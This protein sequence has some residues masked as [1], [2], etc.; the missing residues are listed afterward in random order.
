MPKGVLKRKPVPS[1]KRATIDADLHKLQ[2]DYAVIVKLDETSQKR[3]QALES[4][5]K[6]LA[7]FGFYTT[8][9]PGADKTA[10]VIV[11]IKPSK[12]VEVAAEGQV[13]DWAVGVSTQPVDFTN[14]G[15]NAINPALRRRLVYETIIG[16]NILA[17]PCV[18]GAFPAGSP[19]LN[20]KLLLD[21][22]RCVTI[23]YNRLRLQ[24]GENIGL[25]Y[26][27]VRYMLKQLV[28]PATL[29]V[30]WLFLGE[31][32]STL[33][34]LLMLVWAAGFLIYWRHIERRLSVEWGTLHC[35]RIVTPRVGYNK[36]DLATCQI[37]S[38]LFIPVGILLGLVYVVGMIAILVGEIFFTQLYDGPLKPVMALLPTGANV[39]GGV[40]F[41]MVYS[42]VLTVWLEWADPSSEEVYNRR[43]NQAMFFATFLLNYTPLFLT[44]YLYLPFGNRLVNYIVPLRQSKFGQMVGIVPEFNLNTLRLRKQAIYFSVTNQLVGIL[45]DTVL[46]YAIQVAKAYVKPDTKSKDGQWLRF[47]QQ[48][49]PFDVNKELL[50]ATSTFGYVMLLTPVWPLAALCGLVFLFLRMK[51]MTIKLTLE[52]QTPIPRRL[53]SI[54]NWNSNLLFTAG[55][56]SIAA[57]TVS[58][59]FRSPATYSATQ[60]Y[61]STSPILVLASALLSENLFLG[62]V[63]VVETL[64]SGLFDPV[65]VEPKKQSSNGGAE[66][67]T[68]LLWTAVDINSEISANV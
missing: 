17:M 63:R 35:S 9:R 34:S 16:S 24:Y 65:P 67:A 8:I 20:S 59:M 19:S 11:R 54:G 48:L 29:G 50:V 31:P 47:E 18:E 10:L 61:V 2:P 22:S 6:H 41:S 37:R 21:S 23:D 58:L 53:E 12:L 64:T 4:V 44:A 1:E 7:S 15:K 33:L 68:D 57:P 46:P 55:V 62:V 56:A 38:A 25:L 39:V 40:V 45:T 13:R 26:G 3:Q 66:T 14:E 49:A 51:C 42:K 5:T 28:I 30:S 36:T 52:S 27:F 43:Y 32:F 60:S